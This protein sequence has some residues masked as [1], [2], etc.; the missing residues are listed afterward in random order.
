MVARDRLDVA[1]RVRTELPTCAALAA[2]C[3]QVFGEVRLVHAV[4]N[5]HVLGR[6]GPDGV[7]L[8]E[9]VVGPMV[10]VR[11]AVGK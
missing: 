1:E 7:K 2:D 9:T 3:R 8:S 4:E 6:P 10:V 11:K 5:G